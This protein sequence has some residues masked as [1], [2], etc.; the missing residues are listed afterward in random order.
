MNT[1]LDRGRAGVAGLQAAFGWSPSLA[2][3]VAGWT[4]LRALAAVGQSVDGLLPASLQGEPVRSPLVL[5]GPPRT[6]TTFLHRTLVGLG[7]GR[8]T[9]LWQMV[10]P[11]VSVQ[12]VLR[13][14]LP[15]LERVS[16]ARHH[17]SA[18]H[19]TGLGKMETEDASGLFRDLSGFLA[20]AFLLSWAEEDLADAADPTTD[21]GAALSALEA[22]WRRGGVAQPGARVVA[23]A[24]SAALLV[25]P[26]LA[27]WPGARFVY[28][29]RDPLEAIPSALSLVQGTLDSRFDLERVDPAR[30]ARHRARLVEALVTL[31]NRFAEDWAAPGF[32]QE[33]VLLIRSERLVS[34]PGNTLR[35]VLAHAG[36]PIDA[37][38]E[39]GIARIAT[40][41]RTFRSRH[42]YDLADFGLDPD[43]I[44]AA[45]A[46]W[47][48]AFDRVPA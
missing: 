4:G 6:G 39:A 19:A 28:T 48:R 43:A 16:P 29:L 18:A 44:R 12:R 8:G 26:A 2:L 10:Y 27:R 21:P 15:L 25:R 33:S 3:G 22:L 45:C 31:L 47:Y 23:K 9:A 35:A 14:A 42:L 41:Q 13:P 30:L 34:A 1:T 46:P 38:L 11:A 40:R 5:I 32:P 17:S 37:A 36:A 24:P 20:Y 7:A